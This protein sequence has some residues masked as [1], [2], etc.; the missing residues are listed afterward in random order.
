MAG[1]KPCFHVL[2][3]KQTWISASPPAWL[4]PGIHHTICRDS[5]SFVATASWGHIG[6]RSDNRL[7]YLTQNDI[8]FKNRKLTVR[9]TVYS[10][11]W[12]RI[13]FGTWLQAFRRDQ[14]AS[15]FLVEVVVFYSEVWGRRY[16]CNFSTYLLSND[17]TLFCI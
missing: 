3:W 12:N 4:R 7:Q 14:P 5:A 1:Q 8:T 2:S 11:F 13:Q 15:I 9:C 17:I 6:R 16:T 10:A